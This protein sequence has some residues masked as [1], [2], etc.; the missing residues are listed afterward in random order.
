MDS[1]IKIC[2]NF[3]YLSQIKVIYKASAIPI[4]EHTIIE[5]NPKI[6]V[7]LTTLILL[8][9]EIYS[10]KTSKEYAPSLWKACINVLHIGKTIYP[11]N[12]QNNILYK[13]KE[14]MF[15]IVHL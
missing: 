3:L 1:I 6:K 2:I 4:T 5:P 14:S 7:L 10:L 8:L 13:I 11:I 12:N 9:F 15:L